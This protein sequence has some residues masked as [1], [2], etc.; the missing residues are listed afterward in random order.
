MEPSATSETPTGRA[1]RTAAAVLA[2]EARLDMTVRARGRGPERASP[3]RR[4]RSRA[5]GRERPGELGGGLRHYPCPGASSSQD[6]LRPTSAPVATRSTASRV[7]RITTPNELGPANAELVA[8]EVGQAGA[9]IPEKAVL[10]WRSAR[11]RRTPA[12][13]AA[14]AAP[15]KAATSLLERPRPLSPLGTSHVST[16]GTP[17]GPSR[18][19]GY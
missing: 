9:E 1:G 11:R 12:A 13:T 5:Q 19:R 17:E 2:V 15:W 16:S 8:A 6:S 14:P 10:T 3:A 7:A 4:R 18:Q